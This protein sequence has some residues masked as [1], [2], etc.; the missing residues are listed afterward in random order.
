MCIY[1]LNTYIL[2]VYYHLISVP[3]PACACTRI[4]REGCSRR[5]KAPA[6]PMHHRQVTSK[7]K[8]KVTQDQFLRWCIEATFY[9][10]CLFLFYFNVLNACSMFCTL[11]VGLPISPTILP[12]K[13][14]NLLEALII[15]IIYYYIFLPQ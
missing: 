6:G 12:A 11:L 1:T 2:C 9:F 15:S 10:V 8:K 3:G 13:D 7:K 4:H 5:P 14:E